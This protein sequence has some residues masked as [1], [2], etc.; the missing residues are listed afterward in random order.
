MKKHQYFEEFSGLINGIYRNMQ[1]LKSRGA[2]E[3]G[4]KGV[5]VFWV[6]L[7]HKHPQGMT[8]AE[9]A[10]ASQST[11]ALVSR[12]IDYLLEEGYVV[13]DKQSSHRRYGWKFLLT[14][15]GT[16]AAEKISEIALYV[17]EKVGE[18][19]SR[20]DL[21]VFYRTLHILQRNFDGLT[22]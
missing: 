2:E 11:N 20:A 4:L 19:V 5:H 1:K 8:A 6:Y 9:L 15:K 16:Q 3:L 21:E 13:T 7:L 12:E 10:D 17:Q 18:G 22:R 14:Q